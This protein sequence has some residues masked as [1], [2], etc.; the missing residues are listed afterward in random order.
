MAS[1][2]GAGILPLAKADVRILDIGGASGTYTEA[3]LAE[4]PEARATL[5][6]LPVGVAQAHKRFDGTPMGGRVELVTGDFTQVALPGG[7]DFAWISAI[8][9]QMDRDESRRLYIKAFDALVSGGMV[10]VRDFVMN[11][12]RTAPQAGALFGINMLVKTEKGMVYTF[13]EI[14][15]DLEAAGFVD[16]KHAVDVPTMA[17]IVTAVKP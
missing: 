1:L 6:D 5:F 2:K 12:N 7:H 15:E 14:K 9:H 17:A 8:I 16:V 4:M 13:R 3:F 10:A 11:D